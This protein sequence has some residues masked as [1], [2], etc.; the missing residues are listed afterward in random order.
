M[1]ISNKIVQIEVLFIKQ[2]QIAFFHHIFKK[3]KIE[4]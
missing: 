1:K 3:Q 2:V 4:K